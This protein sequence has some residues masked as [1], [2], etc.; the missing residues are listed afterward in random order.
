MDND[1]G[2]L[3]S[4]Y[5]ITYSMLLWAPRRDKGLLFPVRRDEVCLYE[6]ILR[7][8]L[9]HHLANSFLLPQ[10]LFSLLPK[11]VDIFSKLLFF[12]FLS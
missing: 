10:S 6:E 12:I 1:M 8:R 7:E 2:Y 11:K 4:K 5:D 3:G 9:R